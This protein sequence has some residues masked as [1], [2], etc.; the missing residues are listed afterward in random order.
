MNII[1]HIVT[2]QPSIMILYFKTER[3]KLLGN[4]ANG[5]QFKSVFMKMWRSWHWT[6]LHY[7]A[8]SLRK[9]PSFFAQTPLGPGAKK[10]GCFAG[11]KAPR[12]WNYST[13]QL[14][15]VKHSS[16]N[17]PLRRQNI[18]ISRTARILS[19]IHRKKFSTCSASVD[20]C[21]PNQGWQDFSVN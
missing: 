3:N 2:G 5:S 1:F 16:Y 7:K 12:G 10:D 17:N 13:K 19:L 9:Q 6:L 21:R 20:S 11:Y 14:W 8:P 18:F 4:I 15:P